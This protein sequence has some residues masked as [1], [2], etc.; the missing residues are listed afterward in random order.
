MKKKHKGRKA[1]KIYDFKTNS[2]HPHVCASCGDVLYKCGC[3]HSYIFAY[4]CKACGGMK[5]IEPTDLEQIEENLDLG[6]I[7]SVLGRST[8]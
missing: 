4:K 5:P 8:E 2:T 7:K 6:V 3:S 1:K